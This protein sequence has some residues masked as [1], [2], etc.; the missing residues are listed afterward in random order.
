MSDQLSRQGL[1]TLVNHYAEGQLPYH[2][3]VMPIYQSS[4]FSFPDHA[5]GEA[6]YGGPQEGYTYTRAIRIKLT[7][8]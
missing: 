2:A 3:H 8:S 1:S 6:I 7:R 4:L 5:T